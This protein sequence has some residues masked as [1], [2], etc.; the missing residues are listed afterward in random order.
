MLVFKQHGISNGLTLTQA[1]RYYEEIITDVDGFKAW[2]TTAATIF[3]D[4]E[5]VIFDTNNEYH[6]MDNDLVFQLNQGA[7]DAIRAA[8]ATS[9]TIF[10]EGNSYTGAWTWVSVITYTGRRGKRQKGEHN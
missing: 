9:Q 8:G 6:D 3:A 4:N 10:V 1:G 2:W 7:I 5:L